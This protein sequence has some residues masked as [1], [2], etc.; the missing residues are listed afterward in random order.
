MKVG[1][2]RMVPPGNLQT[3]QTEGTPLQ[4]LPIIRCDLNK[5]KSPLEF[6]I[7]SLSTYMWES[8]NQIIYKTSKILYRSNF[9][10]ALNWIKIVV[11]PLNYWYSLI[12]DILSLNW[13]WFSILIQTLV[14]LVE[15]SMSAPKPLKSRLV[16]LKTNF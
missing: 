11:Y 7:F 14:H 3:S 15:K 1:W 6:T 16:S 5:R 2:S 10:W 9:S 8:N 12:I 4:I 13:F